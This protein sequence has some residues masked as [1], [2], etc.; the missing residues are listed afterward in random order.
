[1]KIYYPAVGLDFFS[2]KINSLITKLCNIYK[3]SVYI[4]TPIIFKMS[5]EAK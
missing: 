5:F 3:N 2:E 4:F 1:M